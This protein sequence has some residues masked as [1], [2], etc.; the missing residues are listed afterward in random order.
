D[1][2]SGTP[3]RGPPAARLRWPKPRARRSI[4]SRRGRPRPRTTGV[5]RT[6]SPSTKPTSPRSANARRRTPRRRSACCSTASRAAKVSRWQTP[7]TATKR[8]SKSP[9]ATSAKRRGLWRS[10]SLSADDHSGELLD[11]LQRR[12]GPFGAAD[13]Q[14]GQVGVL[15]IVDQ[16]AAVNPRAVEAVRLGHCHG[17]A[18][19]PFELAAG[20]QVD[21]RLA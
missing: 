10:A 20:V 11:P 5:S 12:L 4:T 14:V 2:P 18:V 1:L 17:R 15:L 8:A 21:L 16:R 19:V 3:E 7:T 13:Q 9:G 6:S